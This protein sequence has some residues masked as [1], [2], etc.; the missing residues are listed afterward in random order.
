M[1]PTDADLLKLATWVVDHLE[2][3][4]QAADTIIRL[5]PNAGDLCVDLVLGEIIRQPPLE[6][7]NEGT[8][9]WSQEQRDYASVCLKSLQAYLKSRI[10]GFVPFFRKD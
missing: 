2:I 6:E 9:E 10:R 3:D 5:D 7:N 8:R 1:K 4:V